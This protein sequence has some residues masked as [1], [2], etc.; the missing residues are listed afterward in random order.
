MIIEPLF[1]SVIF[2]VNELHLNRLFRL[3]VE[4]IVAVIQR[5]KKKKN[6]YK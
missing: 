1:D 3:N 4:N 6:I 5:L 2:A